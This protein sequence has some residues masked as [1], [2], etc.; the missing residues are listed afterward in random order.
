MRTLDNE[1]IK[2][3]FQKSL[4]FLYP[5]LGNMDRD[6]RPTNTY[7]SWE[8][9]YTEKNF[10]LICTFNLDKVRISDRT[11]VHNHES[12]SLFE[13]R[14]LFGNA[15]YEDFKVLKDNKG[16]YIF[17]LENYREDIKFFLRGR[18]SLMDRETKERILKHYVFNKY[19]YEYMK[20]WLY[21]IL[22]FE[23]Y[24]ELLNVEIELL[25][26]V[27]EL[28][29]AYNREKEHLIETNII[30]SFLLT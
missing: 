12:Y 10:K 21:P 16:I 30:E 18:Y 20:S 28:C 13:K 15:L 22:F 17:N 9:N 7:I 29:D 4:T 25:K 14:Y 6:I 27:G 2:E 8:G 23:K 5:L 26:E 11:E 3:Y 1:T 19:S 24:S